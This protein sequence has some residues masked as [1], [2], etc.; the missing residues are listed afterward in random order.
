MHESP[1]LMAALWVG[2]ALLASMISIRAA[3]SVA[4][5]E[6]CVGAAAGNAI[7]FFGSLTGYSGIGLT[8]TPW[9]DFLA[10]FG[11]I[12]LTFLAGAEIEAEVLRNHWKEALSIGFLSFL[13]P[14]LG[15]MAAAYCV[16]HW[17]PQGAPWGATALRVGRPAAIQASLPPSMFNTFLNPCFN[18]TEAPRLER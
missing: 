4:L 5:T 15:A 13:A 6:I 11:A 7:P 16:L 8:T 9:I 18:R 12:L 1:W 10:G 3:I 17:S 2:L 14:F